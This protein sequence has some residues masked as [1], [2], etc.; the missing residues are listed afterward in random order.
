MTTSTFEKMLSEASEYVLAHHVSL[1]GSHANPSIP[2]PPPNGSATF[3]RFRIKGGVVYGILTAAHV[4][5]WLKFGRNRQGQFLGLSKPQG[6]DGIACSVTFHFIHHVAP[7]NHFHA[8]SNKAYRPDLAFIALGLDRYSDHQ[9]LHNSKFFDLDANIELG[10]TEDPRI[11]SAFFR[12]ACHDSEISADGYMA[13]AL[14]I[15][16]GEV[17][18]HDLET[19][20]QY[21]KVPNTSRKSI[22]GGSGAGFWRFRYEEGVLKKSLEGVVISEGENF[23]FFEAMAPSYPYDSYLGDLKNFCEENLSWFS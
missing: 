5:R 20:V 4:A 7:L 1:G 8:Y 23:D 17:I 9:L 18:K 10:F 16:G 22:G 11:F 2:L 15:G 21:W 19:H 13:T 6:A 14:C 12:G 3:V